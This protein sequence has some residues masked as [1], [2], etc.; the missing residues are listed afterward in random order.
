MEIANTA[1]GQQQKALGMSTLTIFTDTMKLKDPEGEI[2]RSRDEKAEAGDIAITLKRRLWAL[3]DKDG[4]FDKVDGKDL[5]AEFILQQLEMVLKQ[6][7]MGMPTGLAPARGGI[8]ARVSQK[9]LVNLFDKGGGGGSQ[10]PSDEAVMDAE[11]AEERVQRREDVVARSK[12]VA[13]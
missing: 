7:A 10:K 13:Q 1:V 12:E 8:G 3:A 5:D 4:N 2:N 11:E 6:R 9:P